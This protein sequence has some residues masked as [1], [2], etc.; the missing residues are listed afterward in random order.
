MKVLFISHWY[1]NRYESMAGLF[2]RKHALAVNRFCDVT[3]LYVHGDENI[4]N[5]EIE[6][7]TNDNL[8]EVI[9]YYP[10]NSKKIIRYCSKI[11][12]YAKA[13][14][15]GYNSV[16]KDG[17]IPDIVHANIL[18]RTVFF[19]Y[20]LK[21]WKQ[22]PYV[23]SEHWSRY[24]PADK[25][26]NGYIRKQITKIVV[27]NASAVFPVSEL[28]KQAMLDHNLTNKH[29]KLINNVVDDFFFSTNINVIRPKK[30]MLHISCFDDKIKNI[31]GILS[32]TR[33]LAEI[34]QDFELILIGNGNDF[35]E[36]Q[37]HSK[38][39]D[40]PKGIVQ[41]LGEKK[42]EEVANWLKNC[43]LFVLFSNYETAGVVIAESLASGKPVL[44]TKVGIAPEVINSSNGKVID[45]GDEKALVNEMNFLL[46]NL[47]KFDAIQISNE[48]REKFSYSI[49][50]KQLSQIYEQIMEDHK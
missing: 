7:N 31:S 36:V 11:Y 49:I 25:D 8:K 17:F 50:G 29:Y 33:K 10:I 3:V 40:F 28:L 16:V 42:P 30:R 5:I 35:E 38:Q 6:K 18:T 44:S 41:F 47:D 23:I 20:L 34:R 9:V 2:V 32:A 39:L 48:A 24:L 27:R 26:F 14:L 15:I 22:T 21:K 1:P 19:A 46:D 4:D 37:N 45:I 13:Y 43:D 12:Q